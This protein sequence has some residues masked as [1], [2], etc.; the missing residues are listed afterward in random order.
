MKG[1]G[2]RVQNKME[3]F[4]DRPDSLQGS[5]QERRQIAQITGPAQR[6]TFKT[7]FVRARQNPGFIWHTRRIG[8]DGNKVPM[9]FKHA[10]ILTNLLR[11]DVAEHATFLGRKV[12]P[13][14]PQLI[15]HAPRH[16]GCRSQFCI[17]VLE[18]LARACPIILKHTNVFEA[19]IAL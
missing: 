18:L 8:T 7:R 13:S 17:G 12:I 10:H 15:K 6:K 4:C 14:G 3:F 9:P 16:E 11:N 5:P 1:V 19:R 2:R